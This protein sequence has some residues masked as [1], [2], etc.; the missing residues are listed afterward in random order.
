MVAKETL[1]NI[2]KLAHRIAKRDYDFSKRRGIQEDYKLLLK[3]ALKTAW[4]EFY[5]RTKEVVADTIE[6]VY[7]AC[8]SYGTGDTDCNKSVTVSRDLRKKGLNCV[9]LVEANGYNRRLTIR[10]AG[11]GTLSNLMKMCGKYSF[12]LNEFVRAITIASPTIER[13]VM[14]DELLADLA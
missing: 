5:T 2:A 4:A 13:K 8:M 11:T 12:G 6:D 14:I 9:V 10:F 1:R 3:Y 7:R